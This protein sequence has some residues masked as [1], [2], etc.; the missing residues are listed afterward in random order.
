M[1]DIVVETV[2]T[3]QEQVAVLVSKARRLVAFT[4][5]GISTNAGIADFRGKKGIYTTGQYPAGVFDIDVFMRDPSIFYAYV[6]DFIELEKGLAPTFTHSLLSRL[7]NDGK[8]T[9]LITQNIDGLHQKAGSR[10]VLELHGGYHKNLCTCCRKEYGYDVLKAKLVS[11]S[12]P[13]CDSCGHV[14]KPAIVF[15]GEP[16]TAFD[17]ARRIVSACDVLL[18]IGT[19]LAVYPAAVLPAMVQGQVAV[20]NRGGTPLSG[21]H[22]ISVDADIDEFFRGVAT[23]LSV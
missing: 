10:D 18:V 13:R 16:V 2:E 3:L 14:I 5:A 1:E 11:E 15:F 23:I 19:S 22:V 21:G 20:V 6:R 9:H 8:L 12:I 7:Q 4:G 17:E